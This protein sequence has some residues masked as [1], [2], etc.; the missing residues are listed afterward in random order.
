MRLSP[1][2]GLPIAEP[3]D[4]ATDFPAEVDDP[5][6][7]MIDNLMVLRTGDEMTGDL[8]TTSVHAKKDGDWAP[9]FVIADSLGNGAAFT[10][11]GGQLTT[12]SMVAESG[13]TGSP[14]TLDVAAPVT[15]Y[16]AATKNYV[17]RKT[18]TKLDD[19]DGA[20]GHALWKGSLIFDS[21][22]NS[23]ALDLSHGG[24]FVGQVLWASAMVD[25][26]AI[27]IVIS[28]TAGYTNAF[29]CA[30]YNGAGAPLVS[31]TVYNVCIMYA[32]ML[33]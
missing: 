1:R 6:T 27:P 2:A 25:A 18:I 19:P 5:R 29:Q 7:T 23:Q 14:V 22:G 26:S 28:S 31:V 12:S 11:A 13:I 24:N 30:G 8:I 3:D 21:A 17:D 15:A 33:S 16:N 10:L 9:R 20:Y 4:F 32:A